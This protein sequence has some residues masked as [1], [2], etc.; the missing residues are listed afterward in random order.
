MHIG[1]PAQG[2]TGPWS[3]HR[4]KIQRSSMA[5][6]RSQ[7]K[8]KHKRFQPKETYGLTEPKPKT[9]FAESSPDPP[10]RT[11][12]GGL[13]GP[14]PRASKGTLK[15]RFNTPRIPR[16]QVPCLRY[17]FCAI[18]LFVPWPCGTKSG[19]LGPDDWGEGGG[20]LSPPQAANLEFQTNSGH[21]L[22]TQKFLS[23]RTPPQKRRP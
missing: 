9:T 2:T 14:G 15:Y 19:P 6:T 7:R 11:S 3:A 8:A 23:T 16:T 21:P 1:G 18:I 5:L 17:H 13:A 4:S 20:G 22:C 12:G 10:I